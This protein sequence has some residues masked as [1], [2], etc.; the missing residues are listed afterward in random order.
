MT[1][2][3]TATAAPTLDEL[4]T[5]AR[6]TART[7]ERLETAAAWSAH[8]V[9]IARGELQSA[10]WGRVDVDAAAAAYDRAVDDAA[11]DAAAATVARDVATAASMRL[12]AA[13]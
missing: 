1:E 12:A 7:A 8:R 10:R 4:A 11:R 3:V 5:I 9:T 6:V 2:T 13:R